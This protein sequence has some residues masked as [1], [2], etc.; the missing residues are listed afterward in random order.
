ML[1]SITGK[2]GSGKSTVCNLLKDRYGFEIYSTGAFQREVARKMGITTL[3]L[4]KRLREDPSLDYII[5]D[6]VKQMSIEKAEEKLIFDSRMAWHFAVKSFKI[7]LTIDPRE[8]A[9]RVMLN[10]RGSEEFYA[11]ENEA[12]EKLIERSQVEQ[13]RFMQIY[14]VDYYD[15]NNFDLIVDTTNRTPD[16]IIDI[17]MS[18]Y[19]SYVQDESSYARKVFD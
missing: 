5:D 13:A 6:A 8:A 16:E 9:R 10:Q 11:D 12:C 18:A 1:I 2:L 17:I 14:G 7:F 19:E 4:N 15:F 3:E